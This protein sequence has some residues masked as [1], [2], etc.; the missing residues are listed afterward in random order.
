MFFGDLADDV[1][2][3]IHHFENTADS[4]TRWQGFA[5]GVV[6]VDGILPVLLYYE[7]SKLALGTVRK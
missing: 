6:Q 4:Q 7:K 2:T 3:N 5:F 1:S